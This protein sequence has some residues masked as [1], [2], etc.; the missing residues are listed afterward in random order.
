MN[1]GTLVHEMRGIQFPFGVLKVE[2]DQVRK[3]F[4]KKR[5]PFKDEEENQLLRNKI[6]KL[7][8]ISHKNTINL[9][10]TEEGTNSITLVYQYVP[11]SMNDSFNENPNQTVK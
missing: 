10:S 9:R 8:N 11:H 4:I 6:D 3:A 7:K 5:Y 2:E 1:S